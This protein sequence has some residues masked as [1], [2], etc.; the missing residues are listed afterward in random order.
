M[1][2]VRERMRSFIDNQEGSYSR[3]GESHD[4]EDCGWNVPLELITLDSND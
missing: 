1:Q 4:V 3:E 2:I